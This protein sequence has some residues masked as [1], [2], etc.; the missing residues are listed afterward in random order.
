MVSRGLA[1]SSADGT[2]T[3]PGSNPQ[4][5]EGP[6]VCI[7][8]LGSTKRAVSDAAHLRQAAAAG[9]SLV[10]LMDVA[11]RLASMTDIGHSHSCAC[12]RRLQICD[13]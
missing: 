1:S 7:P 9:G 10:T 12:P 5:N 8:A 13:V 2:I 6:I 3:S 4:T 11:K